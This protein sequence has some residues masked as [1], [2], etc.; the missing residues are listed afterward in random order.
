M[1][2]ASTVPVI[3]A[4]TDEFHPCQL[5]ADLQT[6]ASGSAGWPA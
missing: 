5:L 6:S 2:S 3:N 4:L 1:A